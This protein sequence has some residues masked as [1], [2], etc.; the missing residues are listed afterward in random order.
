MFE[1]SYQLYIFT[2]LGIRTTI[3]Y[4]PRTEELK[5]LTG[6]RYSVTLWLELKDAIAPRLKSLTSFLG[7]GLVYVLT[8]II[9]RGIGLVGKG[10][11]Q[12]IG[13]SLQE[14]RVGKGNRR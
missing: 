3:V 11:L 8:Q 9:G 13:N 7:R 1:S 4:A 14:A 5:S 10:I 6:W 12:G 2:E